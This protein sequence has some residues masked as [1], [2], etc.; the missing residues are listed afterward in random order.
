MAWVIDGNAAGFAR[1]G[2]DC[3]DRAAWMRV[4]DE[5][6]VEL[7]R[8]GEVRSRRIDWGP[9]SLLV[10][11]RQVRRDGQPL[12]LTAKEYQVLELLMLNPGRV[13]TRE[14]VLERVWGLGYDTPSNLVDVY[15]KN[16][17]RKLDDGIVE[18]VRGVG[19]RFPG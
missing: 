10:D 2:A 11:E 7:H 6:R 9:F 19:Y 17:R 3:L 13:F 14:D 4:S 1:H 12:R 18:T 8:R 5:S 15:V 16:L